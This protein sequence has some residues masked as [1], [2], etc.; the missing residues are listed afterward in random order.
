MRKKA[1]ERRHA[2][3]GTCRAKTR[4][5]GGMAG[6]LVRFL[7]AQFHEQPGQVSRHADD[8]YDNAQAEQAGKGSE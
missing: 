3:I 7:A 2:G 1:C 6:L 8:E 5:A 4:R